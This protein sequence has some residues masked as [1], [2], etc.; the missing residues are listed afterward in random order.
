MCKEQSAFDV[1]MVRRVG[2][3]WIMQGSM[4]EGGL[5]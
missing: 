2:Q 1:I 3:R 5:N 4:F